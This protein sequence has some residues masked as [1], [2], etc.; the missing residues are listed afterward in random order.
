MNERVVAGEK[1][2]PKVAR[3]VA[4]TV[5]LTGVKEA[6][7]VVATATAK[8]EKEAAEREAAVKAAARREQAKLAAEEAARVTVVAR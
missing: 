6:T 4:S 5:A 3:V 1:V 2:V 8:A 7:A